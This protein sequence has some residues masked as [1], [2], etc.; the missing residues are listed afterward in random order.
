MIKERIIENFMECASSLGLDRA[1]RAM[2]EVV[3][4]KRF[5]NC[6]DKSEVLEA[7]GAAYRKLKV[8]ELTTL[9]QDKEIKQ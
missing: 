1:Y 6:C 4:E 7:L 5:D 9:L 8:K 2:R 3:E